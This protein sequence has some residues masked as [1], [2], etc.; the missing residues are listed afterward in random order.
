MSHASLWKR[1]TSYDNHSEIDSRSAW[2]PSARNVAVYRVWNVMLKRNDSGTGLRGYR[3]LSAS[4]RSYFVNNSFDLLED[5]L[6][7]KT[8]RFI[9][10]VLPCYTVAALHCERPV[11]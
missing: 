1:V 3:V 7:K 10:L 6:P 11:R 9:S 5:L 4:H 8:I 2:F